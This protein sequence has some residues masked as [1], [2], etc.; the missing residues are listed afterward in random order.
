[1]TKN[2]TIILMHGWLKSDLVVVSRAQAWLIDHELDPLVPVPP[3]G[4]RGGTYVD[5]PDAEFAAF[6]Q[7]LHWSEPEHVALIMRG[8]DYP[9]VVVRPVGS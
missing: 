7:G 8:P 3:L 1:M 5:F 6:V 4:V 2:L 9:P